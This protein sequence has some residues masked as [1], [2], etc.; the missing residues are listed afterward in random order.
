MSFPF[1]FHAYV[2]VMRMFFVLLAA[3]IPGIALADADYGEVS[4]IN[5][6]RL[7]DGSYQAGIKFELNQGWKTYWRVPGPAGIAPEFNWNG[8]SNIADI[9][10]DWPTPQV[11]DSA[12]LLT[13]GYKN[14]VILP[15]HITPRDPNQPIDIFLQMDF[16]V[17][18]DICV[19][20]SLDFIDQLNADTANEGKSDI[21]AALASTPISAKSAG[22][23]Q[24]SC[25]LTP[26]ATGFD[27]TAEFRF[28]N[29]RSNSLT[30]I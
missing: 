7:P 4:F 27:L 22:L 14:N 19:P 26:N 2:I 25:N 3:L 23:R 15:V 11:F 12:G 13:I 20:A 24:A 17:C 18:S 6:W 10:I 29:N 1:A 28:K 8:S 21:R 5:G 30:I 16:G 9:T